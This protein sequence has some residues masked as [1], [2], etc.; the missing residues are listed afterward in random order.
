VETTVAAILKRKA[1]QVNVVEAAERIG[2]VV[3][4]L[5]TAQGDAALVID[6]CGQLLGVLAERD[7]VESLAVNAARTLE[8]SAGQLA[9]RVA[10]TV[11]PRTSLRDAARTMIDARLHHVPVTCHG[12][13]VGLI[14]L[15]DVA[16]AR[17]IQEQ[18]ALAA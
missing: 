8:M 15:A 17:L 6:P 2:D 11:N 16:R 4:A 12:E 13:L 14:S 9:V 1:Y 10:Q 18:A 5:S 7:I 3:Q